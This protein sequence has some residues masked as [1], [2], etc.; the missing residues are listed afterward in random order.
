[1]YENR[2]LPY[3]YTEIASGHVNL[4]TGAFKWTFDFDKRYADLSS[5]MAQAVAKQEG[6]LGVFFGLG[7]TSDQVAYF[8]DMRCIVT[9]YNVST[10]TSER[11]CILDELV[12]VLQVSLNQFTEWVNISVLN[13]NVPIVLALCYRY[14]FMRILDYIGAHYNIYDVNERVSVSVT[15][16]VLKFNDKKIVIKG[17]PKHVGLLF[18]GFSKFDSIREVS[19]E[20]MEERDIYFNMMQDL[21]LSINYLRGIDAMFDGFIDPITRD[22][23]SQMGEPTNM[24]D[25]LI[26]ATSLLTTTDHLDAASASNHRFRSYE[27]MA[28]IVYNKLN[29]AL[30]T[31][32]NSGSAASKFSISPYEISQAILT[33]PLL[34]NVET[35]NPITAAKEQCGATHIGEGGRSSETFV[36]K[37]RQFTKDNIGIMSE[38]TVDSGKV[39]ID[40]QLT[41]NPT[42]TSARGLTASKDVADLN[43]SNIL[44]TT[45]LL[46]PFADRDD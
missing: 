3:D 23:L 45:S 17:T 7:G 40:V 33:D 16:I 28:G 4:S 21:G 44:S 31:Y 39:A 43:P 46:M 36:V 1:M 20:D 14:G 11:T 35:L 30:F 5:S 38:S 24:R 8:I 6:K 15:D 26:R 37:D 29:D 34:R 32:K 27:R 2:S 13:K 19:I 22:V 10:G 41:V 9:K 42:I 12:S 18:G 25:L